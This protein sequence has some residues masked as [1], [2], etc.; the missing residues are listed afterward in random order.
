MYT[1]AYDRSFPG[2][3]IDN[4][5]EANDQSERERERKSCKPFP[6]C[7]IIYL[8]APGPSYRPYRSFS[9]TRGEE[10]CAFIYTCVQGSIG[11]VSV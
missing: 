1:R 8:H 5:Q 3:I 6:H 2:S 10:S 7:C 9:R 11:T 4:L